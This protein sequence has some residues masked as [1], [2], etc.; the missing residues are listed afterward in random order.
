[1]TDSKAWFE[2]NETTQTKTI[3]DKEEKINPFSESE[4]EKWLFGNESYDKK[5]TCMIYG[6]D[7]TGKSGLAIS[8]IASKLR[9]TDNKAIIVDLDGGCE[10]L[11]LQYHHD[12]VKQLIIKNPLSIELTEDGVEI[13]YQTIVQKIRGVLN[14]VRNN[15]KKQK[16]EFFVFDGLSTLLRHAERQM[17]LEKHLDADGGVS[18][19]YWLVRNKIFEETLELAKAIGT[20]VIF[21]AHED[22][23]PKTEE[24]KKKGIDL[25]S[26]KQKTNA[27]VHQKIRTERIDKK[28]EVIF[29][30]TIDKSKYNIIKEGQ[31]IEFGK[32]NKVAKK[33]EW[34]INEVFLDL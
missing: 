18:T 3:K 33:Y 25:A 21:I 30:A 22:F 19:R 32:V 16:I 1:M 12:L 2:S 11:V 10:P 5:L 6:S 17:R 27:L 26:I 23:I 7:G 4:I 34:N 20:N 8:H 24:E 29:K 9:G 28:D 31:V 13:S 15:Y 14:Y